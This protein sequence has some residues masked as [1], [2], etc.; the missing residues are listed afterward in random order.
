MFKVMKLMFVA[1][2]ASAVIACSAT[3]SR[4]STGEYLDSTSVTTKVKAKL[5]DSLGTKAFKIN[6]K[7][8]KDEVQLSGFVNSD[9]V[10]R[11]AGVIA[12]SVG[13]VHKVRNDLVVK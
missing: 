2:L 13:D 1:M 8:Y 11:R 6:V 10:K 9:D 5:V 7:T 12:A 4:E 3:P